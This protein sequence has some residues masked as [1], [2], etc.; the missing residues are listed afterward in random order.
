MNN[1]FIQILTILNCFGMPLLADLP[2]AFPTTAFSSRE[3]CDYV[4]IPSRI[5]DELPIDP[6]HLTLKTWL[7]TLY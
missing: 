3:E 2:V 1:P 6:R 4:D 7:R 5:I